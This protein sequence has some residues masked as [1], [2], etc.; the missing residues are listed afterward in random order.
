M[1]NIKCLSQEEQL[2][3]YG[4]V[5]SGQWTRREIADYFNISTDTL[6][7]IVKN[8]KAEEKAAEFEDEEQ[9]PENNE[10]II[11]GHRPEIVWNA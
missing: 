8:F 3:A 4:L 2:E 10:P 6:R 9:V 1:Y 11:T 5:K 7:K